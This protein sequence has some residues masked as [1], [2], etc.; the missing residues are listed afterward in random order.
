MELNRDGME[1]EGSYSSNRKHMRQQQH[2]E[3]EHDIQARDDSK[4]GPVS[5][6]VPAGRGL[7]AAPA[8]GVSRDDKDQ[9]GEVGCDCGPTLFIC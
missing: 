2:G 3:H 1:R 6:E 8:D 7:E 5:A 9:V 4:V